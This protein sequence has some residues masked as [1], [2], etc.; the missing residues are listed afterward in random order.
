MDEK[1][2]EDHSGV[3]LTLTMAEQSQQWS[4]H[5]FLYGAWLSSPRNLYLH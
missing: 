5:S 3:C 2:P 4:D 1:Q